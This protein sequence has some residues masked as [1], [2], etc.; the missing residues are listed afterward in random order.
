MKYIQLTF[1]VYCLGFISPVAHAEIWS[2][3]CAEAMTLLGEARQDVTEN[4]QRVYQSKLTLRLFPDGLGTCRMNRRGYGGGIV[5]CVNHR[6]HGGVAIKEVM[7]AERELANATRR[8]EE[9]LQSLTQA[10]SAP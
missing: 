5:H 8:F 9:R 2:Y 7:H 4:H 1:L 10:C 3:A 6:S